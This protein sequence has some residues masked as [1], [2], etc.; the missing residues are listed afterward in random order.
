MIVDHGHLYE[1]EVVMIAISSILLWLRVLEHMKI[2]TET[3]TFVIMLWRMLQNVMLFLVLFSV[4]WFAFTSA[5]YV[6]LEEEE[7][8]Q[9]FRK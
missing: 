9:S 2:L 5:F 3:S 1:A 8:F 4:F 7:D 6:L